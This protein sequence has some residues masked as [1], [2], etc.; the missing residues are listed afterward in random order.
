MQIQVGF[1]TDK[2][3]LADLKKLCAV[4]Q[5]IIYRREGKL[6]LTS[7]VINEANYNP[8]QFAPVQESNMHAPSIQGQFQAVSAP[9]YE[10]PV[11]TAKK[12]E[13]SK[14]GRTA[15]GGR[16]VPFEDMTDMMSKIYSGKKY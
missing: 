10:Q 11:Q 5:T 4:L 16:I 6:P 2:E 12:P 13:T 7:E 14:E 1:D 9:S 15:G 3:E 8:T